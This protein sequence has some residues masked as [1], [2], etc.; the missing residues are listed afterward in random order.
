MPNND[1]LGLPSWICSCELSLKTSSS[2]SALGL[3]GSSI[4]DG[5]RKGESALNMR[6]FGV[7]GKKSAPFDPEL[8]FLGVVRFREGVRSISG[9]G[10]TSD[11]SSGRTIPD[12]NGA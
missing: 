7:K 12:S 4:E 2:S 11:G 9:L 3:H 6:R 5:V 10:R 8:A 1:P